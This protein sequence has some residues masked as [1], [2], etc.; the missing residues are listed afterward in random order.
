MHNSGMLSV[1]Q[2]VNNWGGAIEMARAL[3]L[4]P[5][6]VYSWCF[7]DVVPAARVIDVERLTGVPRHKIRPDIFPPPPRT[8]RKA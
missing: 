4:P 1:K 2:I 6:T 5:Q 7:R 3:R 8:R